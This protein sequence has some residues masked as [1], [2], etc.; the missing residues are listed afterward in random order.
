MPGEPHHRQVATIRPA[1]IY[2]A[3]FFR[4]SILKQLTATVL[5]ALSEQ[6]RQSPRLRTNYNFHAELSDP[7]QRL[8]IA[9]EP[10]TYVRPHRHATTWEMLI[11]VRGRF[12]VLVFDDA[13]AVVSRT[14]LGEECQVIEFPANTWHAVLSLDRGGVIFE[15]KQG[16]YAPLTHAE[17]APWGKAGEGAEAAEMNAWYAQ[18]TIGDRL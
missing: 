12:V 9:M 8:A 16:P 4:G 14:V 13:G 11:P 15:V 18:A 17:F 6:A 10:A 7:V 3:S 2:H 1:L 5:D